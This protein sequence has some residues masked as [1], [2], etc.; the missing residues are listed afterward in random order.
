M[1]E[2]EKDEKVVFK[3]TKSDAISY[4]KQ[5]GLVYEGSDIPL[6]VLGYIASNLGYDV[7]CR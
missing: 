4:L 2:I 6:L 7:Y 1:I 5:N 3:G